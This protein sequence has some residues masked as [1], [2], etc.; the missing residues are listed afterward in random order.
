[1][2]E[3]DTL[4]RERGREGEGE[5]RGR[6]EGGGEEG[7]GR[8]GGDIPSCSIQSYA[9]DVVV[10]YFRASCIVRLDCVRYYVF[11]IAI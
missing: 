6:R 5:R 1:M 10:D 11:K 9:I 3:L 7:R 8:E 4:F 2:I